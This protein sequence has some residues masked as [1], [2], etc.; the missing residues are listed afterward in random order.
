M[1]VFM[2]RLKSFILILPVQSLPIVGRQP[3]MDVYLNQFA[4]EQQPR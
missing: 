1:L 4:S 2:L 3:L